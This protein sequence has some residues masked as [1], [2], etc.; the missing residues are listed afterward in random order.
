M[1]RFDHSRSSPSYGHLYNSPDDR[2]RQCH[3][4]QHP[5]QRGNGKA[6]DDHTFLTSGI[7]TFLE[8]GRAIEK[9]RDIVEHASIRTTQLYDRKCPAVKMDDVVLIN[10]RCKV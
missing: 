4:G 2:R 3:N 8:N 6:E 10:L 5:G 7:T 1:C 9:G